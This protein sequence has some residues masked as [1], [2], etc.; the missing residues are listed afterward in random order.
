MREPSLSLDAKLN[1]ARLMLATE[2][3]PA[4]I[5]IRRLAA[6]MVLS[7]NRDLLLEVACEEA[8]EDDG[9]ETQDNYLENQRQL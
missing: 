3:E 6:K 5:E 8:I 9:P 4:R 7:Q 1:S 2:G